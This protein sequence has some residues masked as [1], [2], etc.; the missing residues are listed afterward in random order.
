MGLPPASCRITIRSSS[1]L[2]WADFVECL[3]VELWVAAGDT[4][5]TT[6]EGRPIDLAAFLGVVHMLVDLGCP[7]VAMEYQQ[8]SSD[9]SSKAD[10]AL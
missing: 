1:R 4:R 3:P 10:S 7:V 6:L 8:E 5:A 2:E 9:I